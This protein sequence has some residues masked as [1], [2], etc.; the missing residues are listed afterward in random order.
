MNL[1]KT[2]GGTMAEVKNKRTTIVMDANIYKQAKLHCTR[3]GISIKD[4]MNDAIQKKLDQD[5]K[6]EEKEE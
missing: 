2:G 6:D 4:F 1:T 5:D 3:N